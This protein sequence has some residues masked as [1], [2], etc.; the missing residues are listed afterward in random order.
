MTKEKLQEIIDTC[1]P[2][3][4]NSPDPIHSTNHIR[5]VVKNAML[6]ANHLADKNIDTNLLTAICYLHDIASFTRR[7]SLYQFLFEPLLAKKALKK[8]LPQFNLPAQ[9]NSLIIEAV[10][11][12]PHAFP[13]R[14]L[15]RKRNLY[16][17]IL[18]DADL[19]D[20]F[21]THQLQ[22]LRTHPQ[23]NLFQKIISLFSTIGAQH[24][25]R[26]I[27]KYYNQPEII[28]KLQKV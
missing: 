3:L 22:T 26:N 21:S 5:S 6:I 13:F 10:T 19:F 24:V 1:T 15:N 28:K 17:Q 18:Q 11:H 25:K 23:R 27:D 9:E 20:Q 16:C 8:F 7:A 2:L 14:R 12:H 4:Q